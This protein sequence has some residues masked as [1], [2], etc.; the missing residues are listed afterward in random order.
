MQGLGR[1]HLSPEAFWS[2]TYREFT[3]AYQG[4]LNETKESQE[5]GITYAWMGATLHKA[6]KIPTIKS[7]LGDRPEVQDIYE[8]KEEARELEIQ[9]TRAEARGKWLK[10][11][12]DI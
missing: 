2:L 9:I 3:L 8:A 5:A 6:K 1:L 12:Y 11:N 10:E 4:Y 7:L